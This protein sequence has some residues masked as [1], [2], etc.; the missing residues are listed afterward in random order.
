[1]VDVLAPPPVLSVRLVYRKYDGFRDM[2]I[3][4]VVVVCRLSVVFVVV[5]VVVV[6]EVVME[7]VVEVVVVVV[8][9]FVVSGGGCGDCDCG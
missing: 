5:V 6:V 4:W 9:V 3:G 1:M 7:V 2:C 8:E